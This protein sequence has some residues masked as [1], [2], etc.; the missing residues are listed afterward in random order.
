MERIGRRALIARAAR[1]AAVLPFIGAVASSPQG[2]AIEGE[3]LAMQNETGPIAAEATVAYG[4][5]GEHTED[6][7]L[8]LNDTIIDRGHYADMVARGQQMAQALF[9]R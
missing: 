4:P 9:G 5:L 2:Q 8:W 1:Y 3:L 6:Y 7:G